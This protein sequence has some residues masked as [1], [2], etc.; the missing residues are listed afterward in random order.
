MLTT[1]VDLNAVKETFLIVYM[2]S[3]SIALVWARSYRK[4][5]L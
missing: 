3:A 4:K 5:T 1:H 2:H